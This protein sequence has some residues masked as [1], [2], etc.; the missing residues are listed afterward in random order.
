[1]NYLAHAYLSFGRGDIL[2]GNMGSDFI[3]GKKKFDCP[4]GMQKGIALHRAIDAFTDSHEATARAK[5]FFRPHYRLYAGAFV[6][7]VYDHFLANDKNE[8][9]T[10][11]DL[12]DFSQEIY[13]S[14]QENILHLPERLKGMLPFMQSQN[15]LYHYRYAE[16]IEKSFAG[17]VR[18]S[19]YLQESAVAFEV[20]KKNYDALQGCYRDFF[21][22]M[23]AF[24]IYHL[25]ALD[26]N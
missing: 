12:L 17:L 18:R 8:F 7:V 15:W 21:P 1:M 13:A 16:G 5:I 19:A 2:A 14:L 9:A 22:G 26:K 25:E 24:A 3:K 6:D 20:F 4:A 10:E 11:G 23:K